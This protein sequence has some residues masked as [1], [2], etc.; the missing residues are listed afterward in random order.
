MV[1]AWIASVATLVVFL[2]IPVLNRNCLT[3]PLAARWWGLAAGWST[4]WFAVAE[5][6]KWLLALYP[7]SWFGRWAS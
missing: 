3:A 7:D 1:Y 5:G 2:Y 4:L 6:R